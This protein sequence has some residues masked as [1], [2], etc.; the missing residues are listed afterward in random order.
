[1]H[2]N[3][4]TGSKMTYSIALRKRVLSFVSGGGSKLEAARRFEISVWCV[5]DWCT[6]ED[7]G[8][9]PHGRRHR[10]LDWDAL[11][12]HIKEHPDAVLR[13]R[14]ARFDVHINA[15]WYACQELGLSHKKNLP[16]QRKRS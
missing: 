15:I 3:H 8:P 5:N 12:Q 4:F 7:L 13:E 10:K 1:M 11:N 6:R 16:L 9:K 2:L 14:A